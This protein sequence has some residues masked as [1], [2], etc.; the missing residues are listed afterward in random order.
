MTDQQS[1][2]EAFAQR[3]GKA[4]TDGILA[5][6]DFVEGIADQFQSDEKPEAPDE[7]LYGARQNNRLKKGLWTLLNDEFDFPGGE[8]FEPV[9]AD[10]E[11]LLTVH[12]METEVVKRHNRV[13][14]TLR[15]EDEVLAKAEE[16][17][18]RRERIAN[19]SSRN[20][21]EEVKRTV[22]VDGVRFGPLTEE[23]IEKSARWVL[24]QEPG[25]TIT[26]ESTISEADRARILARAQ[27]LKAVDPETKPLYAER[28]AEEQADTIEREADHG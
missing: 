6:N 27:A 28:P 22:Y 14:D 8:A 15:E 1:K 10:F 3:V 12:G 24:A 23:Q 4:V 9:W 2:I 16:I 21:G 26:F 5:A 20:L 13:M 17:R 25:E 7:P 18:K 19:H 11:E